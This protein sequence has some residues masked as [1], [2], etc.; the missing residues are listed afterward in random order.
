MK[1]RKKED[2]SVLRKHTYNAHAHTH[3]DTHHQI[4]NQKKQMYKGEKYKEYNG[5]GTKLKNN[6]FDF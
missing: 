5:N 6:Q 1:E 3:I 2:K 4:T